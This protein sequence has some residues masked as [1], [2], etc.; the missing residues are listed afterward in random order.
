MACDGTAGSSGHQELSFPYGMNMSEIRPI[1]GGTGSLTTLGG[2]LTATCGT[3]PGSLAGVQGK[4]PIYLISK[5]IEITFTA[6]FDSNPQDGTLQ[7]VG[8]GDNEQGVLV[9]YNGTNFGI[10]VAFGGRMQY[11]FLSFTSGAALAGNVTVTLNGTPFTVACSIGDSIS[12]IQTSFINSTALL[13]GGYL[14]FACNSGVYITSIDSL[15]SSGA[16]AFTGGSTGVQGTINKVIEGVMADTM[17]AYQ[18]DWNGPK[19]DRLSDIDWDEGNTFM[20]KFTPLGFGT[21]TVYVMDPISSQF[22]ILHTFSRRNTS[23]Q[24]YIGAGLWPAIY[25]RNMGSSNSVSVSTSGWNTRGVN[26][27]KA[28]IDRPAMAVSAAQWNV[29]L[30]TNNTNIMTILSNLVLNGVRNRRTVMG[31]TIFIASKGNAPTTISL[32][33]DGTFSAPIQATSINPDTCMCVDKNAGIIVSGGTIVRQWFITD[34]PATLVFDLDTLTMTPLNTL[35]VV[36]SA[37]S[38]T[39]TASIGCEISFVEL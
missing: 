24:F 6:K 29:T 30:S 17:W 27:I 25:S 35:S 39:A 32:I 16:C 15:P 13:G 26:Y 38:G 7:V 4:Y 23:K 19:L 31:R 37:V 3:Y 21:I 28:L 5:H 36:C 12:K 9:G 18:P 33:R 1:M 20:M 2:L 11:Y 8:L 14:V 34:S 22:T 10:G